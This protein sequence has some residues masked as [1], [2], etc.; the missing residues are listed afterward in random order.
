MKAL[1][2][3]VAPFLFLCFA[4]YNALHFKVLAHLRRTSAKKHLVIYNSTHSVEIQERRH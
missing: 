4:W 2:V 3:I 1:R